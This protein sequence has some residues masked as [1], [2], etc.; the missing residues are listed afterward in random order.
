MAEYD[1]NDYNGRHEY[2]NY[3]NPNTNYGI[4]GQTYFPAKARDHG[5]G[6]IRID[7]RLLMILA[8]LFLFFMFF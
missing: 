3:Y 2:G 1:R 6:V 5:F 7:A 8:A 4:S